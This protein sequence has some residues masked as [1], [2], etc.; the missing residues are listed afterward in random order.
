MTNS[1][2]IPQ[3]AQ[4]VHKTLKDKNKKIVFVESCSGGNVAGNLVTHC[5]GLSQYLHGSYVVYNIN[6]K[7]DWLG[8]NHDYLEKYTCESQECANELA[9]LASEK[10]NMDA[11]AVVGNI[12]PCTENGSLIFLAYAKPISDPNCEHHERDYALA[13]EQEVKLTSNNRVQAMN[14]IIIATYMF[15]RSVI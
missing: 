3:L 9:V 12:E 15:T 4:I 5:P 2:W 6:S 11:I 7:C 1:I 10:N 8:A 14:E 13:K